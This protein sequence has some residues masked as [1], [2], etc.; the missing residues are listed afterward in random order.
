M[1]K[2]EVSV[3]VKKGKIENEDDAISNT[4]AYKN[5]KLIRHACLTTYTGL[6]P[7]SMDLLEMSRL[8]GGNFNIDKFDF[9]NNELLLKTHLSEIMKQLRLSLVKR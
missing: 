9:T 5:N 3:E 4:R 7:L 6:D 8:Q 2:N 1:P